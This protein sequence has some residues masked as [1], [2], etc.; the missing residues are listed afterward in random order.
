MY[1]REKYLARIFACRGSFYSINIESDIKR[2]REIFKKAKGID[3]NN[4]D[5]YIDNVNDNY[6]KFWYYL[7]ERVVPPTKLGPYTRKRMHELKEL[8]VID[9]FSIVWHPMIGGWK[10]A[11]HV[12]ALGKV[13]LQPSS[14]MLNCIDILKKEES[15]Q[16]VFLKQ[17]YLHL[18][19]NSNKELWKSRWVVMTEDSLQLFT[20]P[21][22]KL[23]MNLKIAEITVSLK[24]CPVR[25][26]GLVLE[27]VS[28][29]ADAAHILW[30]PFQKEVF[31]WAIELRKLKSL[32][33]N[34]AQYII[35]PMCK[36]SETNLL[37][38]CK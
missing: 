25:E 18:Q 21:E 33:K 27:I 38:T 24:I 5:E 31:E 8:K 20:I 7:D 13:R 36:A 29:A 22:G 3:D 1:F 2:I 14:E 26:N 10:V 9:D 37:V 6:D 35:K 34:A 4:I 17:G 32:D 16:P 28:S 23:K 19:R 30:S 11:L 12:K 15:Q